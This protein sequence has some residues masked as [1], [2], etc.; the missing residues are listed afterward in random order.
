M[1]LYMV[2]AMLL[3]AGADFRA[4]GGQ[5]GNALQAAAYGGSSDIV[6]LLLDAGADIKAQGGKYSNAL[7]AAAY[8]GSS[9]I[10]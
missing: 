6:Q 8:G 10:V 4:Q 7:Q 5:Y 1:L 2:E 3:D 9:D